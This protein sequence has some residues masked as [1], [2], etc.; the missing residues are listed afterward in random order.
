MRETFLFFRLFHMNY[1]N[2]VRP[3]TFFRK[4]FSI[5]VIY[6]MGEDWDLRWDG[7][8]VGKEDKICVGIY[9]EVQACM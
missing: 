9:I 6:D 5:F 8:I 4:E 7:A 3:T 1:G 2:F